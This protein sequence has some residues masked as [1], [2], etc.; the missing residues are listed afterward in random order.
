[1]RPRIIA[2]A[3]AAIAGPL[4]A[5]D[6]LVVHILCQTDGGEVRGSGVVVSGDGQVLTAAHVLPK[7]ARCT[8]TLG[9]TEGARLDLHPG[10]VADGF[11]AALARLGTDRAF[12]RFATICA[13]EKEARITSAGF[14]SRMT[15]PPA[16]KEG[17][18]STVTLE[19]GTIQMTAPVIPAE[20][21]GPV[22]LSGTTA[23]VGI[24]AG[25]D[26]DAMGMPVRRMVPVAALTAFGLTPAVDCRP[27]DQIVSDEV[28]AMLA[29]IEA[30]GDIRRAE[31]EGVSEQAIL[32]L[33]QRIAADVSTLDQAIAE[34]RNAVDIAIAVRR[35]GDAPQDA[36]PFV[37]EVLAEVAALTARGQAG[38]LDLA[39]AR[40]D[41]ALAQL[42]T[43]GAAIRAAQIDLLETGIRTDLLRRDPRAAAA[44]VVRTVELEHPGEAARFKALV[45]AQSDWYARGRD[46]GVNIELEVAIALAE[47]M[48]A[49]ADT[50][51]LG[52]KSLNNLGNALH[53]LGARE[54]DP[55]RLE[56]AIAAYRA[57][58]DA[59][60]R[61]R[62]PYEWALTLNNLGAALQT[63]GLREAGTRR[64]DEAVAAYRAALGEWTR[65]RVPLD[66]AATNMNLGNALLSLGD[67]EDGTAQLQE[68]AAAYRATLEEWTRDRVPLDWAMAQMNLGVVLKMIGERETGTERLKEAVTAMRLALEERP[69]ERLPLVW[70]DNQMNLGNALASLGARESDTRH[71]QEAVVAFEAAL[72][73]LT[74]D[75]VPL[76]WA[77]TQMNLGNA[78][79]VLG[80]RDGDVE[81]L[82]RALTAYRSALEVYGADRVP[83]QWGLAMTNLAITEAGLFE[84]TAD[85]RHLEAA[86]ASVAAAQEVFATAGDDRSTEW[87]AGIAQWIDGLAP[88]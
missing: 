23:L 12:P 24:V 59:L 47:V 10:P 58:L 80:E 52:G 88:P 43:A 44:R 61:K 40:V 76:D 14:H 25:A 77:R 56:Q 68:A 20:S 35:R 73:E 3:F 19:N 8:A 38:D 82:D 64:L 17:I 60:P 21:G 45:A 69:R 9:T 2:A 6:A 31:R 50:E 81:S 32:M 42:D 65:D 33:A 54:T 74:R 78:L 66:W 22:F 75:R 11:D 46:G 55:G 62:T 4:W 37:N 28:R 13:P 63:A 72:E 53:E 34:L 16:R 51:T 70:A 79:A 1:M 57:A 86:R 41:A 85:A 5:E 26:W 87:A 67:R 71:V 18:V 7:G 83:L 49:R 27:R 48:V 39:G 30:Q 15:G 29:R 36:S 84:L